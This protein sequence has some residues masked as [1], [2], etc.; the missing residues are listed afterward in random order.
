MP[1]CYASRSLTDTESRYVAIETEMLA[2]VLAC[3]K[4]HQDIYGRSVVVETDH[5]PLQTINSK[6]LSQVTFRL[7]KIIFNVRGYDVKIRYV[8]GCKQVLADTLSRVSLPNTEQEITKNSR[9]IIW[10][11]QFLTSD[12]SNS[13]MRLKPSLR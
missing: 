8:P 13:R 5:K 11:L 4:L 6:P 9:K 2:V 1:V 3:R 12:M 7:Q 10:F